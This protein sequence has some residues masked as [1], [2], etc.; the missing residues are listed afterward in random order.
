MVVYLLWRQ[1]ICFKYTADD[2]F[3]K[4]IGLIVSKYKSLLNITVRNLIAPASQALL[5]C[6][7][8]IVIARESGHTFLMI[9]S[10]FG[11][12]PVVEVSDS[13]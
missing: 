1:V 13:Y 8:N 11:H 3:Q 2:L 6:R 12:L 4:Q 10:K 9:A 5:T 7:A